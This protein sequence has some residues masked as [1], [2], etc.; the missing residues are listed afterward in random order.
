[1]APIAYGFLALVA[2]VIV[3][4]VVVG[5]AG[6]AINGRLRGVAPVGALAT[7]GVYVLVVI[8]SES[9]S[10]WKIT[11]FGLLPLVLTF[12]AGSYAT[13]L[14]E[15]HL[16]LRSAFAALAGLGSALLVG[17]LYVVLIRIEWIGLL[18]PRTAWIALAVFV[19]LIVDSIWKRRSSLDGN[20]R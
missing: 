19:C 14:F 17:L 10:A 16:G 9:V 11:V 2:G 5:A 4:A 8:G 1:M 13:R 15:A 20:S 6:G 18:D 12:S 3:V 7:A